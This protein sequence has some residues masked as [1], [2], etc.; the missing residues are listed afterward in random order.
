MEA[1][2]GMDTFRIESHQTVKNAKLTY[3]E[4]FGNKVNDPSTSQKCHWK[5]INRVMNKCKAPKIP[6]FLVNNL[7][8]L[9]CC[10]K[11]K[12]LNDFFSKQCTPIIN[13]SVLLIY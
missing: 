8:I 7:F 12:L 4:N 13:S 5:I 3:L 10:E 1:K 6:P 2:D 11:V 9:N